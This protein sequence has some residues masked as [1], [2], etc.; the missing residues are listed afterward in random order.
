MALTLGCVTFAEEAAFMDQPGGEAIVNKFL[1]AT[2]E[3]ENAMRGAS[4]QVDISA[5]VPK[6]QKTGKLEALRSISKLGKITYNALGFSGDKTIKN[7][8]IA[9]YLTAETQPQADQN[10]SITPANYKFKFKGLQDHEGH[11]VYVFQLSPRHKRVGLFKGD[12]WIDPQ[13]YMPVRESGKFVKSPSIFLK[14][15]EFVR[16]YEVKDGLA[17]P[18]RLES[19][20]TT[21]IFG[22]VNLT[23]DYTNFSKDPNQDLATTTTV[24]TAQ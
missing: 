22:P 13:S 10:I 3:Q 18:Q 15:V 16:T 11:Q 7:E 24:S 8:V 21:R 2:E 20:I 23:I 4:M 6:L 1:S 5:E 14:K 12:L 17:V 19:N 9:R